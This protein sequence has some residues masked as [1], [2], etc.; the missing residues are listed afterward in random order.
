MCCK[1]NLIQSLLLSYGLDLDEWSVSKPK[2]TDYVEEAG[3]SWCF[4]ETVKKHMKTQ[5][6]AA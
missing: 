3:I 6:S 5:E 1:G 2:W 4:K